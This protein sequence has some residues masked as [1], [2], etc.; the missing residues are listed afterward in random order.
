M[1]QLAEQFSDNQADVEQDCDNYEDDEHMRRVWVSGFL[2]GAALS[3]TQH[4]VFC[5]S[6]IT[7]AGSPW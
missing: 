3:F 1:E 2:G 6:L 7:S 5:Y 4:P